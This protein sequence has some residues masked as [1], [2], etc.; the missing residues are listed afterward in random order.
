LSNITLTAPPP[1]FNLR[2]A[3]DFVHEA[4]YPLPMEVCHPTF[5]FQAKYAR[6]IDD[7]EHRKPG[8]ELPH[9]AIPGGSVGIVISIF[10]ALHALEERK[11]KSLDVHVADVVGEIQNCIGI[12]EF[13]T[14]R[15][16]VNLG[17]PLWNGCGYCKGAMDRKGMSPEGREF[18]E[19]LYLP[20]LSVNPVC[21]E[22]D[23]HKARGVF[24]L[25][26]S[27]VGLAPQTD[28]GR[29]GYVVS[30]RAS[31]KYMRQVAEWLYA[32][33]LLKSNCRS[34][35][36]GCFLDKFVWPSHKRQLAQTVEALAKGLRVFYVNRDDCG[37]I[38]VE[39][40]DPE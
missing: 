27:D 9:F 39:T 28:D 6:C 22:A 13:H 38:Q 26:G 2:E 30:H 24:I 16:T 40:N 8:G 4:Y 36:E 12:P 15:K 33:I 20:G 21:Y 35:T 5:R 14:D 37:N 32:T 17:I 10:T 18:L 34:V 7:R 11:G 31:K 25:K 3:T 29:A 1:K 23:D 19:H